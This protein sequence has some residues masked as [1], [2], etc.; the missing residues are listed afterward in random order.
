MKLSRL[1]LAIA[2]MPGLSLAAEPYVAEPLVVTSGR[3]AEPQAQATAATTVF[4]RDDI[5]RLQVSSVTEL[6]TCRR[7]M[8]SR[9]NTVV[10]AVACACGSARR[11]E[12]TTSGSAT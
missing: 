2:V 10:A 11:P 6:L 7:S 5:E 1:A 12:V 9:L 8:S 3:L 4:E